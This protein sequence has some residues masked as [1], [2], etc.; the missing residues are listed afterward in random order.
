MP[1]IQPSSAYDTSAAPAAL[2]GKP[3]GRPASR[4]V[5]R[6]L[7]L[8]IVKGVCVIVMVLYHTIG[9][10]P[11]SLL[12]LKYLAFVTGAFILLAGFV[13]TNIYLDKYDA[14]RDWPLICQ[15]LAVRGFKLILMTVVLNLVIVRLLPHADGKHRLDALSTVRNLILGTDYHSVSFD[16][17]LLIGY[18]LLLTTALF[19]VGKGR[20]ALMLPFAVACVIYA[21]VSNYFHWTADYYV[22]L[23]A[24]GQ[25][26]AALGLVKRSTVMNLGAKLEW[27]MVLYF[28]QILALVLFPSNSLLYAANVLCTVAAIYAVASKCDANGWLCR[29]LVL[30]GKYSLLAYLFQI[31]FLQILRHFVQFTDEGVVVAFALACVATLVCVEVTEKLRRGPRW[32]E[33]TYRVVFC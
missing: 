1:S 3:A 21:A 11:D 20:T 32:I 10:Y 13:S 31:T 7:A 15:R 30:L 26:G 4:P 28:A 9:Y 14:R 16:L 23:L 8:D 33:G 12:S 19:A 5:V 24:I 18:S 2:A 17:L 6:D 22:R 29:K 27:V 25:V